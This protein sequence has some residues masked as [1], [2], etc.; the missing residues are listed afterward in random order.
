MYRIAWK[1]KVSEN[2]GNGEFN[3]TEGE[4][5]VQVEQFNKEFPL[6]EYW[7]EQPP[8]PPLKLRGHICA[9]GDGSFTSRKSPSPSL[10][11]ISPNEPP[12]RL[13]LKGHYCSYGDI[14]FIARVSPATS[15]I[16]SPP[17]PVPR[18]VAN[19]IW[20]PLKVPKIKK[21]CSFGEVT[22]FEFPILSPC[23]SPVS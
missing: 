9:Y 21:T 12:A 14:S 11:P 2:S 16:E 15:P 6:A 4:A 22:V 17:S 8:P 13:K 7:Y 3:L 5:K 1:S 10:S 19:V 23:P 18:Q 20:S